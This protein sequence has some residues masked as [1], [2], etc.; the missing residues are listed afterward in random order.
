MSSSRDLAGIAKHLMEARMV[1]PSYF[2]S[3]LQS[4]KAI[5]ELLRHRH[6]AIEVELRAIGTFTRNQELINQS[7]RTL[8]DSF[9][10]L[11]LG[12]RR[13]ESLSQ[14]H[15]S[16]TNR[17]LA[18]ANQLA[19]VEDY[20][21]KSLFSSFNLAVTAEQFSARI[22]L[23]SVRKAFKNQET[24]VSRLVS[25]FDSL[26]PRYRELTRCA[27]S[28]TDFTALPSFVLP[29]ASREL[30]TAGHAVASLSPDSDGAD[31]DEEQ[32]AVLGDV[33]DATSSV[34]KLLGGVDPAL[35]KLYQ[36]A[37]EALFGGSVDRARHV[38]ASLRELWNHLLRTLA[39]DEEV[40]PWT[41]GKDKA[42][43][44]NGKPTRRARLSYVCREI[45]HDPLSDFLDS[46]TKAFLDY[47]S[48]LNRVHA[49]EPGLSDGQLDALMLRTDSWLTFIVQVA[50]K[51][52][53]E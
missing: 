1:R 5:A 46:D 10:K 34:H 18:S 24:A 19:H 15:A 48:F 20:A 31:E 28:L 38:L 37:R 45:N 14:V 47:I 4:D 11:Q 3:L 12:T 6:A 44:H 17:V 33:R 26:S 2:D 39:P 8:L 32:V 21:K 41:V 16:W 29:S 7:S 40:L 22:E 27:E 49:I 35:A 23:E 30:L 52:T 51:G 43:M 25:S 13:L 9:E 42:F 53:H 50:A 36:G